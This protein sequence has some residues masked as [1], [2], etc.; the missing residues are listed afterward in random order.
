MAGH[1][2][3]QGRSSGRAWDVD[4]AKW[5]KGL[6]IILHQNQ[7]GLSALWKMAG[8]DAAPAALLPAQGRIEDFDVDAA[9]AKAAYLWSDS[10]HPAD[11]WLLDLKTGKKA[12]AT[13]SLL[14]GLKPEGLS[15]GRMIRYSSFD[16]KAVNAL[17]LQPASPRLGSPPPLVVI[18][19]GGPDWQTYDDFSPLRQAL[20]EAGF[21]VLAPNFRGSTG[22]G[23]DF[24]AANRKDWG[25]GDLKDLVAG[26]RYLSIRQEADPSRVGITGGSYGGH[27]TLMALAKTPGVWAAG[28]QC[29]G[30]PDLVQDNELT[31]GRFG[32]WYETQ[33]GTPQTQA[34][35]FKE[36]SA[37]HS[38]DAIKAP[39][40]IFQGANDTNV[41]LAESEL[42]Y[43]ELKKLGRPV[44]LVVYPDEGHGF[45]KRKNKTDYVR[46][47]VDFFVR[48]MGGRR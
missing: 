3:G 21:A 38:L 46:R 45:T 10:A 11:V 42:V 47:T 39:L 26:V 43:N 19:H 5:R 36:R 27:L 34:A 35:L 20:A 37:I 31:K 32:D 6:G 22:F 17:Y 14:A 29:Y 16:G 33:M 13:R 30:M 8:P 48:V 7:G 15:Q 25:G 41:P 23:R 1:G 24:L 40:L 2:P 12:P 9:G 44:E 18:P 28:A 4:G